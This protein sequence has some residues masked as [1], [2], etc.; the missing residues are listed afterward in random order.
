MATK[1]AA[2]TPAKPGAPTAA[3]KPAPATA[4]KPAGAAPAQG[5]KSAVPTNPGSQS[6]LPDKQDDDRSPS[7]HQPSPEEQKDHEKRIKDVASLDAGGPLQEVPEQDRPASCLSSDLRRNHHSRHRRRE[8]LC[9]HRHASP[10]NRQRD[11]PNR[12][13][14]SSV[15][16]PK[17][18]R[19][20]QQA[21]SAARRDSLVRLLVEVEEQ[22]LPARCCLPQNRRLNCQQASLLI[23]RQL[24]NQKRRQP[25]RLRN[26]PVR[27]KRTEARFR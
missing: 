24:R 17:S 14:V 27:S 9:L 7:E 16:K 10:S 20:C 21:P 25:S 3:A 11:H 23:R 8:R 1:Q 13:L 18:R 12:R 15:R 26:L 2:N 4:G 19:R 6:Q 22:L 5:A